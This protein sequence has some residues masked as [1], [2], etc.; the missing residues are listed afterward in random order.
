MT[1]L[2]IMLRQRGLSV[3]GSDDENSY[4]DAATEKRFRD[5]GIE[6]FIGFKGERIREKK[7]DT[8]IVSAAFGPQNPEVKAARSAR[9]TVRTHSEALGDIMAG[10]EGVGVAGVHGKTTTTS[11][12]AFILKEAGFAPS[13]AI[14]AP[15]VPDLAGSAR[16]GDGKYFVVEADEYKKSEQD[17]TP[18]F[19]DLPLK[20]V[21]I[22]SIELDHPDVYD[23]AEDVYKAFYQLS[24]RIPRDGTIVACVDSPLVRRLVQ[25]RVDL[26]CLTYGFSSQAEYAIGEVVQTTSMTSFTLRR[27]GDVVGRFSMKLPGRHNALNATGAIIMAQKLGVSIGAITK[28]VERFDGP[29]RR[30]ERLGEY[31]EAPIFHDYA[32]HPTAINYLIETIKERF[33]KSRLVFVFQPHTYSRTGKLI[34][35]FATSLSAADQLILLNIYASAREKSGYVTIKDLVDE[36]RKLKPEAEYRS[37]LQE[38]ATYLASF[39]TKDHVVFLVGAGDVH[40]IFD[41]LQSR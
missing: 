10:F 36:V 17:K 6:V 39:I 32:H 28:A 29:A 30:F 13:Y 3:C 27:G 4:T 9:I 22:T 15:N 11:L 12:L 21:I 2:A 19:M 14:G 16:L 38:A 24:V 41:K 20:H 35:E 26:K 25:R 5:L 33:P 34:K 18:R 37:N 1:G 23:T 40:K 7:P 31:N 8:I